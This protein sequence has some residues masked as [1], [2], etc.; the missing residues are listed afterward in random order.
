MCLAAT[1]QCYRQCLSSRSVGN[2]VD[3][4]KNLGDEY[5]EQRTRVIDVAKKMRGQA[6]LTHLFLIRFAPN[7]RLAARAFRKV[8]TL[9]VNTREEIPSTSHEI[10]MSVASHAWPISY[11]LERV[12]I[13]LERKKA[14]RYHIC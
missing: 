12:K 11:A 2:Q 1:A 8:G 9:S 14:E 5:D 7:A 4:T 3:K 6:Y 10:F 13:H